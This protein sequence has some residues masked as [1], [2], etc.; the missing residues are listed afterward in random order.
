MKVVLHIT[1]YLL[2]ALLAATAAVFLTR[3]A[4]TRMT[5]DH[6]IIIVI[7][8]SDAEDED[9]FDADEYN[10]TPQRVNRRQQ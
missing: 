1:S 6:P 7:H 4:D 2:V 5:L 8:T 3:K 10:Q 9:T